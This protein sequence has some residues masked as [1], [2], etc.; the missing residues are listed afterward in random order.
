MSE[1]QDTAANGIGRFT[2]HML[3]GALFSGVLCSIP[4]LNCINLLFCVLNMAGVVLALYLYLKA[5]PDDT[6]NTNESLM[7]GAIAGAGAGL[8]VGI[9][10]ALL[11]LLFRTI[12]S[13]VM[14]GLTGDMGGMGSLITGGA[15]GFVGTILMLPVWIIVYAAF[16]LLGSF[17]GMMLFF[18]DRRRA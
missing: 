11:S 1:N 16:G 2:K 13:T 7:F 17:L 4:L 6:L 14:A 3:L 15:L 8:I 18:K 10:G 12:M 9:L 5:N